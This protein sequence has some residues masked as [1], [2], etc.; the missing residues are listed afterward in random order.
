[1]KAGIGA[2]SAI[3]NTRLFQGVLTTSEPASASRG[4][5]V[6]AA[7]G[8]VGG[9]LAEICGVWS[10][11]EDVALLGGFCAGEAAGAVTVTETFSVVIDW[12]WPLV[13]SKY[14]HVIGPRV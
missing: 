2:S 14:D 10:D 13:G 12:Y 9:V 3:A 5:P 6:G 1:M 4:I 7:G 8:V 11:G